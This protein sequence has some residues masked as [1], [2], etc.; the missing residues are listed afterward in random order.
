MVGKPNVG[1]DV[2]DRTDIRG[3]AAPTP[4]LSALDRERQASL[5]D[6]GGWAG[7]L[8][9]SQDDGGRG[10]TK[11]SLSARR[12]GLIFGVAGFLIGAF[13]IRRGRA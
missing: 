10:S 3:A 11:R 9:E 5:A 4:G 1:A 12:L 8:M 2:D 6:E 7:A 13:L